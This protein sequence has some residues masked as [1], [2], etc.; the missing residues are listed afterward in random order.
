MRCIEKWAHLKTASAQIVSEIYKFRTKVMEYDPSWQD[1]TVGEEDNEDNQDENATKDNSDFNARAIFAERLQE[2]NKFAL[3][4]VGEDFLKLK[5]SQV[6]VHSDN[7]KDLFKQ[8]LRLYVPEEVLGGHNPYPSIPHKASQPN[9]SDKKL[10]RSQSGKSE[11]DAK[12]HPTSMVHPIIISAPK[13]AEPA[14]EDDDEIGIEPDDFVSPMTIETYINYRAKP[15]RSLCES[16]SA[17]LASRLSN[18]KML[19]ILIGGCGTLLAAMDQPRWVAVTVAITTIIMNIMQHEML[20]QRLTSTNSAIR[21]LQNNKILMDSLS[22][23]SK[24]TQEMKTLCVSQ[25]ETAMIETTTA[26]TGMTARPATH[27]T[28]KSEKGKKEK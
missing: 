27:V 15:L 28:E 3:D 19:V 17:P 12:V 4:G 22:I 10:K 14:I 2:I 18:L 24:R 7:Q 23:V 11:S 13:L 6:D 21:E 5:K 25:V 9:Q 20:Q 26:W 16:T 1:T 8:Q